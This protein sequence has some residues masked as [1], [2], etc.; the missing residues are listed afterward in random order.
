MSGEEGNR[1]D[2]NN[3]EKATDINI[4]TNELGRA[5]SSAFEEI[6]SL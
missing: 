3:E 5:A 6:R 2:N 4:I 1:N